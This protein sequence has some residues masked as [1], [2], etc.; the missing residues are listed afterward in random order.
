MRIPYTRKYMKI[1]GILEKKKH[2]AIR[3]I[4]GVMVVVGY[5][6]PDFH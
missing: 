6:Y 5:F 4:R 1:G 3:Q 2:H